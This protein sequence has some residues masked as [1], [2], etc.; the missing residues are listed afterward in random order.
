MIDKLFK[1]EIKIM[2]KIQSY[3]FTLFGFLIFAFI[4]NGAVS[5][6]DIST[7]TFA[8]INILYFILYIRYK[9]IK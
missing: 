2:M 4:M 1:T 3:V 6:G 8:I 5:T 7:K 9:H